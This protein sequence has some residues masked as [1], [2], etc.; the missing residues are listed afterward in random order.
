MKNVLKK[1]SLAVLSTGIGFSAMADSPTNKTEKALFVL[2]SDSLQT[3]G[4]SMVLANAMAKQGVQVNVL[5]CDKAGDLALKT[6]V[7]QPLKP[8]GI[9][10]EGLMMNLI[11]SG[12]QVKVCALY[13]PN[14]GANKDELR[15]G[16][17]VASPPEMA[18]MMGQQE[19]KVI[20]N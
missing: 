11:K 7:S 14:K 13:L 16:I 17:T 3:Q 15:E 18:A 4:M 9:T 20:S 6:T 8:M 12:A 2:T 5:L 10:P 19:T 1:I